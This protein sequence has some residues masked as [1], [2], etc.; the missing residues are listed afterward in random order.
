MTC[1]AIAY[2]NKNDRRRMVVDFNKKLFIATFSKASDD[3]DETKCNYDEIMTELFKIGKTWS[4][5]DLVALAATLVSE[6]QGWHAK[7]SNVTSDAIGM[8]LVKGHET[9]QM[10]QCRMNAHYKLH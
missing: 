1:D 7:R 4:S 6:K 2:G 9:F 5:R 3:Y 8:E 10:V